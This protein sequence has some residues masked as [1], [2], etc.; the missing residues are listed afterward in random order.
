M[1]KR[2]LVKGL[3]F[4]AFLI[5]AML[6]SCH[7]SSSYEIYHGPAGGGGNANNGGGSGQA[8]AV[9]A[10]ADSGGASGDAGDRG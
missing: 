8:G 5:G 9:E 3:Y 10:G 7:Q 2:S 6:A 1:P 4:L